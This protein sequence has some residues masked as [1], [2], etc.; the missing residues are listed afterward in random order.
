MIRA[1]RAPSDDGSMAVELVVLTPALFLLA[2][3]ILAFGRVA[4]ARQQ[5]VEAA[6][7]GAE[8]AAVQPDSSTAQEGAAR[9]AVRDLFEGAHT[10]AGDQV[11]VDVGRFAPGGSVTVDVTCTVTLS[12]LSVP[13]LPGSTTL[14]ASSTAPVDPYRSVG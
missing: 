5:V 1:H 12:D 13:G 10:C 14:R 8:A 11:T 2:I 3:L 7:A 6:R 4:E 9:L